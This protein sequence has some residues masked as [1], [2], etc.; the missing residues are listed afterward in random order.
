MISEMTYDF[1]VVVASTDGRSASQTVTVIA[2]FPD[3]PPVSSSSTRVKFNTD[4]ELTIPGTITA[5]LSIV[6]TWTAYTSGI[7]IDDTN[8]KE[9]FSFRYASYHLFP[10]CHV[11]QYI[12]C[13]ADVYIPSGYQQV[14]W[15]T[16]IYYPIPT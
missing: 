8:L 3:A 16:V 5:N 9:F 14:P 7:K 4:S 11:C 6:A 13:R 1:A 12:L 15:R 10:P 2:A